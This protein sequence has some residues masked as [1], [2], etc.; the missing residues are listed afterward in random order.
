MNDNLTARQ[1]L[2]TCQIDDKNIL[3]VGGYTGS[4]SKDGYILNVATK[5]L[6]RTQNL[7]ADCFPF[8]VP[9]IADT[10]A[11]IAYTVDWTRYKLFRYKA[12]IWEIVTNFKG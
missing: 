5:K 9:T 1:G 8:A 2:G 7:P 12:D 11:K 6:K 3:I 4:Y 10:T